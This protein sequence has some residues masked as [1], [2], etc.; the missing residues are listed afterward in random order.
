MEHN[1]Y[2]YALGHID[3]VKLALPYLSPE[4]VLFLLDNDAILLETVA[5]LAKK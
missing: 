5:Q 4:E 1:S 2:Y 3:C